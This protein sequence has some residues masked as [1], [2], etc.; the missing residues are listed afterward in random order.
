LTSGNIPYRRHVINT[1][2]TNNRAAL[3]AGRTRCFHIKRLSLGPSE[4][5]RSPKHGHELSAA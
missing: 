3:D 5:D 4:H 1:E 2:E